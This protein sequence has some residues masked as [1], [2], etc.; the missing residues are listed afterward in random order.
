MRFIFYKKVFSFSTMTRFVSIFLRLHLHV[1]TNII[2]IYFASFLHIFC[3]S[4]NFFIF[5]CI[6][7][8]SIL[9]LRE[10]NILLYFFNKPKFICI[11]RDN[12]FFFKIIIL[13]YAMLVI[14]KFYQL[15]ILI[16]CN[17]NHLRT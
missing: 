17:I 12:C 1:K 4:G 6:F 8:M 7:L 11:S 10:K 3:I 2:F 9:T 15:E 16:T 5:L 13:T 14:E